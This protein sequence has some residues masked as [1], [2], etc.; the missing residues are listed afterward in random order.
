MII[1]KEGKT[2]WKYIWIVVILAVIVGTGTFWWAATHQVPFSGWAR[3]EET[4]NWKIYKNE[5]YN[6]IVKYP[7][8]GSF[9]EIPSS[10]HHDS[11]EGYNTVDFTVKDLIIRVAA[12]SNIENY[13][14]LDELIEK[15]SEKQKEG[16]FSVFPIIP[17]YGFRQKIQVDGMPA[18]KWIFYH[19]T[20][21]RI[22][23]FTIVF[24]GGNYF[25]NI[26]GEKPSVSGSYLPEEFSEEQR[27]IY[28]L[29][30]STFRFSKNEITNWKTYRNE[31]YGFEVKY[32]NDW[33]VIDGVGFDNKNFNTCLGLG[34][35]IPAII[36]GPSPDKN[37]E[38]DWIWQI[39][40]GKRV[41][42]SHFKFIKKDILTIQKKEITKAFFSGGKGINEEYIYIF[43]SP[44]INGFT[45]FT[46]TIKENGINYEFI[47]EKMLTTFRYLK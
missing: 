26:N 5:K 35:E 38:N 4:V 42:E 45:F 10:A 11:E 41:S 7:S 25:Y 30:L 12:W 8:D 3:V 23:G 47:I 40:E 17:P 36:I 14:T 15:E 13:K 9:R 2:N 1:L 27:R 32:P 29:F 20:N 28:D 19:E 43:D 24:G 44:E 33:E 18:L 31:E 39:I 46:Y 6:Y 21:G 22:G 16:I 37:I 34:C